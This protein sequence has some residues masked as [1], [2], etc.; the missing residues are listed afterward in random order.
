MV[1]VKRRKRSNHHKRRV[2]ISRG[3]LIIVLFMI[4]LITVTTTLFVQSLLNPVPYRV[5]VVPYDFRV[6]NDLGFNAD[7]DLL[8]F[9]GAYAGSTLLRELLI[10]VQQPSRVFFS[11]DGPGQL[12][13]NESGF[14]LLPN[15]TKT[16]EF[17]LFITSDLPLGNYSGEVY[18]WFYE[19]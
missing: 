18:V 19:D 13:V 8:H 6:K 16:V 3:R 4:A 9:G 7:T 5:E 2:G 11:S 15:Q 14:S 17:S 12:S 1:Q 10:E